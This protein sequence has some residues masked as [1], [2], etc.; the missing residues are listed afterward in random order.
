MTGAERDFPTR[1]DADGIVRVFDFIR[2][3]WVALTPEEN[4]RQRFVAFLVD[5]L[6]YPPGRIANEVS[7]ELNGTPRRCDTLVYDDKGAPLVLIEYKSPDVNV[8]AKTFEQVLR[9]A[10]VLKTPWI[11]VS[12]GRKNFCAKIIEGAPPSLRFTASI[13][14][15]GEL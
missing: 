2:R 9:Y 6:K 13:P 14:P 4:I 5:T 7:L 3:R 15:Y 8:G 10:L 1:R 12:N 11:M